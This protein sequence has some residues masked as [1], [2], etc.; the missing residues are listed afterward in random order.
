MEVKTS[1]TEERQLYTFEGFKLD[2]AR[3]ALSR[4]DGDVYLRPQSFAVLCHLVQHHGMLV[5]REELLEAVWHNAQVGDD[6]IAQCI[7][8]IRKTI[9]DDARTMIRTVPKR[10]FVFESDV[11]ESTQDVHEAAKSAAGRSRDLPM[12][13]AAIALVAVAAAFWASTWDPG[14]GSTDAKNSEPLPNSIAV[15]AFDDMSESQDQQYFGD[16]IAEE[17]LTQLSEIPGLNVIARTSSFRLQRDELNI[18]AI[19]RQLGVLYVLE[20]S[21]RKSGTKMRITAQLIEVDSSTHVWSKNYDLEVTADNFIDVQDDVAR[22]VATAIGADAL[23]LVV[24]PDQ[25]PHTENTKALDHHL[26]GL[27]FLRQFENRETGSFEKAM[28]FFD[29]AIAQDPYWAPPYAGS[30]RALHFR[31]SRTPRPE[32]SVDF[33]RA[34]KR[35]LKAIDLNPEYAPA[36]ESLAFIK[37][38]HDMDFAESE[39]LYKKSFELGGGKQWGYAILL[40]SMGRVDESVRHYQL[41][42]MNDPISMGMRMQLARM[43]R[44]AGRYEESIVHYTELFEELPELEVINIL[45]AETYLRLGERTKAE[46]LLAQH[47]GFE[48]D[49]D[50]AGPIHAMLGMTAKAEAALEKLEVGETQFVE[51]AVRTALLLGQKDRALDYMVGAAKADPK[52]LMLIQCDE[53]VVSL[54]NEPRYQEALDIAGFPPQHRRSAMG[55]QRGVTAD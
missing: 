51:R 10:G 13:I 52:S 47:P 6:S 14:G 43:L 41:G 18:A 16:G 8:E 31:A 50:L 53:D 40:G 38:M 19:A 32:N 46:E 26:K 54:A 48:T 25:S 9:G 23:S 37:H 44:C 1:E 3:G 55:A 34:R 30:A 12:L 35:L 17:V 49:P 22:S 15:L 5:S 20:G 36:Y 11:I 24:S 27:Y 39:L 2:L 42:L 29:L 33:E 21:V 7:V 4:A 45:I 28:H